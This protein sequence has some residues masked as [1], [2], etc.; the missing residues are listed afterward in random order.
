MKDNLGVSPLA[1]AAQ[2]DS[3]EVAQLLVARGASVDTQVSYRGFSKN[4][5]KNNVC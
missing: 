5:D 1:L 3:L 2:A 4:F